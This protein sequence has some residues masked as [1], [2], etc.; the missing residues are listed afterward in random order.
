MTTKPEDIHRCILLHVHQYGIGLYPVLSLLNVKRPVA[1]TARLLDQKLGW[2]NVHQKVLPGGFS[3]ITLTK[4]G[5]DVI[6]IPD[7][8]ARTLSGYELERAIGRVFF[9]FLNGERRDFVLPT[10]TTDLLNSEAPSGNIPHIVSSELGRPCL[11]R[12]AHVR[13]V[14]RLNARIRKLQEEA[15]TNSTVKR[16]MRQGDYGLAL[17]CERTDLANEVRR[18]IR[19]V[20]V[21]DTLPVIVGVGPTSQTFSEELRRRRKASC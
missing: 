5:C 17:L 15:Q 6:G 18:R 16:W 12:V 20:R 7:T 21:S 19:Q 10:E 3:F 4:K 9:C 8:F 11:F 1:N 13:S 2:V 14:K